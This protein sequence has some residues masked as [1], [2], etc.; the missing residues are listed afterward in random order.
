MGHCISRTVFGTEAVSVDD[1]NL[2]ANIENLP[3]ELLYEIASHLRS[4]SPEITES[5]QGGNKR[6]PQ[7]T[8]SVTEHP[9][10]VKACLFTPRRR[11][12]WVF[13]TRTVQNPSQTQQHASRTPDAVLQLSSVSR[14]FRVILFEK[15]LDV[16]RGITL[17]HSWA[18]E[19]GF[20]TKR[21]RKRCR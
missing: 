16:A 10:L 9:A 7:D 18:H 1:V 4:Q 14:R 21:A 12:P 20:K 2:P 19:S 3:V 5:G 8:P 17:C 6:H 11:F 15:S 13:G